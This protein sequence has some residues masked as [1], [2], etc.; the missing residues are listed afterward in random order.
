MTSLL[1]PPLESLRRAEFDLVRDYFR[2]GLRV[3]ELGGGNGFQASLLA[4][5]GCD[6]VS[7]DLADRPVPVQQYF[8]VQ[9]YDGQHI[10]FP[11]ASFDVVY[12]SNVLEHVRD[13]PP[14]LA[15]LRRVTRPGGIGI[16]IMP[17]SIWRW[18]SALGRYVHFFRIY[19]LK[20]PQPVLYQTESLTEQP[21]IQGKLRT[22]S[23]RHLLGRLWPEP[24]GEYPSWLVELYTFS[25]FHWER[26]FRQNGYRVERHFPNHLIYTGHYLLPALPIVWRRRLSWIL[27]STCHI[28]VVT[29]LSSPAL[30]PTV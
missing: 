2:P 22:K 17:T 9:E 5:Q 27:G 23:W 13:L 30:P 10:P 16:H 15:E 7:I 25:R 24:H 28:F 21:T 8:P 29:A 18:W 12:S 6:I 19:V 1:L 3:L 11:D 20:Q 14:M 26:I 4:A